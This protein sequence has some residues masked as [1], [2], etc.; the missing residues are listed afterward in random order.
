MTR[1][2]ICDYWNNRTPYT[3]GNYQSMR[4]LRYEL[5]DYMF[6]SF[7]FDKFKGKKVLEIGCGS[8]ID[9]AEFAKNGAEVYA[10]DMSDKAVNHTKKVFE[11]LKLKGKISKADAT[12]LPFENDF[13]DLVYVY[14]VLHHIPVVEKAMDEIH[15]V[16][17]HDGKCFAMLYH[18]DSLLYYYSI[19]YLGGV[20][21]KG[22]NKGLTEKDILARYSEGKVG[23]PYSRVYSVDEAKRLFYTSGFND[24]IVDIEYPVID[25]TTE[26]KVK[27][28][29]IPK[30]LGWHLIVKGSKV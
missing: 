20:V 13:F 19:L 29:N 17:K 18:K 26:R 30:K 25:T 15:R 3:W 28:P 10:V 5:Q 24:I 21:L 1:K 22:F 16:L 7:E 27:I 9:S 23:N 8:G 4:K 2:D 11:G 6:D 12:N 14:G